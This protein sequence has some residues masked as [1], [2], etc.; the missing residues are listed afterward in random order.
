MDTSHASPMIRVVMMPKDTNPLGEIFGG[1]ILSHLDFAAAVHARTVMPHL[2]ATKVV[3]EVDFI[4]PVLIGDIV[5]FYTETVK[6]GRTS[7]TIKVAV[8]ATRGVKQSESI[9]VTEAEVV[10]VA[11]DDQH[12]PIPI[13]DDGGTPPPAK[14]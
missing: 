2:Y 1:V 7:I 3:R 10:M 9:R 5:S 4:A 8:E 6:V 14:G 11:I 13:Y 12:R